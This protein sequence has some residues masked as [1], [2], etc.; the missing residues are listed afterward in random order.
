MNPHHLR[1]FL[2]VQK[3][4]NFTRAAEEVY[5]SQPA[6]SRQVR[7]L[8]RELGVRLFEQIGK[9][10][11]LTDAGRTFAR[12]AER[13]LGD[14]E[15]VSEAV[16]GHRTVEAGTLR[17]GACTSLG[18]YVLPSILGRFHRA[19]P[20]VEL[21]YV[22]S[23]SVSIER[24]LVRNDLDLG[25]VG[26]FAASTE[27]R[28]EPLLDDEIVCFAGKDHPLAR[29]RRIDPRALQ[30]EILVLREPGSGTREMFESWAKAR[31]LRFDRVIQ[32]TGPEVLKSVVRGGV[33]FSCASLWGVRDDIRRGRMA[34]LGVE[35]FRLKRPI[36][37]AWHRD[38]RFSPVME[39]FLKLV[40]RGV[41]SRALA[42]RS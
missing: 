26:A 9:R 39:G 34:R 10:I 37:V 28:T 2:A 15:R 4:L 42:R 8:E 41:G 23:N 22:V 31:R 14:I 30:D 18:L 12:E 32:V 27:I 20:R 35:G 19:H 3:H 1:T 40:R 29:R 6:V 25:F 33:G 36:L 24:R 7:Q 13:L 17:I 11:D 5:L 21:G 38:K 16:Q